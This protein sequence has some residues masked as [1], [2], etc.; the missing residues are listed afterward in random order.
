[1]A[2]FVDYIKVYLKAG[3]GGDGACSIRREKFKPF[4]GP[5]GGSGGNGSS[6]IFK[7]TSNLSSLFDFKYH[8]HITAPKGDD[9]LGKNKDGNSA[10]NIIKQVP[11]GT[12]ILDKNNKLIHDFTLNNEEVVVAKGGKGGF[13]N[14]K[15]ANK[16]RIAPGFALLGTPGEYKELL[17]ELKLI[18]D[19]A[20]VGYPSAGKS[21]LINAMSN[22]KAKVADYEFT[23]L[24]PN[25]GVVDAK[26]NTFTI[27]DV[28]GLIEGAASGKGM[29]YKF[30]RHIE[31]VKIIV[32]VIDPIAYDPKRNPIDDYK[33]LEKELSLYSQNFESV[34][35]IVV[36]NKVDVQDAKEYA[37]MVKQEFL[38]MGLEVFEVSA[39]TRLG[40]NELKFKLIEILKNTN[41]NNDDDDFEVI[42]P[43]T[44][45]DKK[46]YKITKVGEKFKVNGEKVMEWIYQTDFNNNE[47][48]GYLGDRLKVS[49]IEDEL[50]KMGAT[51]Q[52]TIE[53]GD[54]EDVVEF[55]LTDEAYFTYE[56]SPR[57]S[58]RRLDSSN[59]RTNKERKKEDL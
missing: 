58:D 36:L 30:L 3:R 51:S 43:K 27:A 46:P 15:L 10:K 21:S 26:E 53:F 13:G 31:R 57:G 38:D 56:G 49:G 40:V 44:R 23:T 9:G 50:R 1:M 28:P 34:K 2:E 42:V 14:F 54:G 39:A 37:S 20:L 29:G 8:P 11:L 7:A 17:L 5:D 47:A 12:R 6:I 24:S 59:R 25:L 18:A 45:E 19:V 22:A 41:N 33:A 4:G 48:V 32:H 52:D 55:N 35:R 16:E